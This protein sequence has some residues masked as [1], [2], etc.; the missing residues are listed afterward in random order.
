MKTGDGVL[1]ISGFGRRLAAVKWL[2]MK[3]FASISLLWKFRG[4]SHCVSKFEGY[5][6]EGF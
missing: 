5:E 1:W 3:W 6:N 2:V 4:K